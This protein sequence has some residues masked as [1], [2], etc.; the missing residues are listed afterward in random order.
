MM[1]LI[2]ITLAVAA[3]APAVGIAGGTAKLQ[4]QLGP[5]TTTQSIAWL[6][7]N[8]ARWHLPGQPGY[9]LLRNGTVYVVTT[10][11]GETTVRDMST[12]AALVMQAQEGKRDEPAYSIEATG[13]SET[14]AGIAGQVYRVTQSR[15]G[16]QK[17]SESVFTDEPLVVEMTQAYFGAIG[18]T[19]LSF[20]RMV[21]ALPVDHPGL[22]R[23]SNAITLVEVS[24]KAP[25]AGDFELPAEPANTP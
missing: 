5:D 3:L 25:P 7:A 11:N 13:E 24:D 22:L 23:L 20:K 21:D 4:M 15:K 1:K 12:A 17:T 10:R 18:K 16:Q 9:S 8:T 14:I 6:D 19:N 2:P